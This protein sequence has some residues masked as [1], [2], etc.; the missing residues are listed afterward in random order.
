M[1]GIMGVIVMTLGRDRE[2]GEGYVREIPPHSAT[3]C[4][5]LQDSLAIQYGP[6]R[7]DQG[8]GTEM[9]PG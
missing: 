3:L 1:L 8:P 9:D 4:H 5:V 6:H 2:K 7:K